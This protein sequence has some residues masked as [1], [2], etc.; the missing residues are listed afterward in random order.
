MIEIPQEGHR[1]EEKH[2]HREAG[3]KLLVSKES[4]ITEE[5]ARWAAH[6]EPST[7]SLSEVGSAESPAAA[8]YL[9]EGT[10]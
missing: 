7:S 9:L 4:E 6:A 10:D 5:E 3:E 1:L 8:G 2:L